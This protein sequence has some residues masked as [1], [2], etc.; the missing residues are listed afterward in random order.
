MKF[1]I[2]SYND[3]IYKSYIIFSDRCTLKKIRVIFS[4]IKVIKRNTLIETIKKYIDNSENIM[5]IEK[6][7]KLYSKLQ[8]HACADEV[9]KK[10][11]VDSI[12]KKR[13]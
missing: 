12:Q 5:R 1:V 2:D 8:K 13:S 3:S 6:V 4:N 9:I 10:A 11:Y 7:N